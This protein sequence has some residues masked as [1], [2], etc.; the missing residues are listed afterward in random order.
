MQKSAAHERQGINQDIGQIPTCERENRNL[1]ESSWAKKVNRADG[2]RELT[3][4][5]MESLRLIVAGVLI[6]YLISLV[7]KNVHFFWS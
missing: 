4:S 6:T 7:N 2:E 1:L 5:T 3:I